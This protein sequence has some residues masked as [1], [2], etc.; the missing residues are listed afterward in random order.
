[1]AAVATS[2]RTFANSLSGRLL[3][4]TVVFV[5]LAEVPILATSIT[6][7]R[8]DYL[9]GRIAAAH[10]AYEEVEYLE[11]RR[12][13]LARRFPAGSRERG[14]VMDIPAVPE[15]RAEKL[16]ADIGVFDITLRRPEARQEILRSRY[17]PHDTV[18]RHHDLDGAS[19]MD[20][21]RDALALLLD[22]DDRLIRV[23]GRSPFPEHR[24]RIEITL[25]TA[26]MRDAMI[27]F[28]IRR[29]IGIAFVSAVT[30]ILLYL[31]AH[32]LLVRPIKRVSRYMEVYSRNPKDR[33][34]QI[35]PASGISEV[36]GMETS[37]Q[38]MQRH[39]TGAQNRLDR[40]ARLGRAIS[41]I[42]HDL[43]NRFTA[44]LLHADSM[45][46]E[47]DA[48]TVRRKAEATATPVRRAVPL[49]D[50]LTTYASSGVAAPSFEEF[51]LAPEIAKVAD[52]CRTLTEG[53]SAAI[54]WDVPANL[55][56][57]ADR[58]QIA[59]AIGNLVHN[60]LRAIA[61]TGK[62][63]TVRIRAA[64]AE[65]AWSIFVEDDGPG[66]PERMLRDLESVFDPLNEARDKSA[67]SGTG[68]SIV[69]DIM[70]AHGG[71][72]DLARSD[73]TGTV[74]VM[75]LPKQRPPGA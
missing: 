47:D 32:W 62:G 22:S 63:E 74:F 51:R 50:Q 5:T 42:A 31:A 8:Q 67:G 54:L 6:L 58:G 39:L 49:L 56:V 52:D 60:A 65:G 28:A 61:V 53:G 13:E 27:A 46:K 68:L 12:G 16:L 43:T 59:R 41:A 66:L 57:T 15:S 71:R 24:H 4:L 21:M 19:N 11:S 72:V 33:R 64:E 35:T 1:M 75:T 25:S 73:Q 23:I 2:R 7:F 9:L 37:L 40:Q 17:R 18:H 20:L 3:T 10:A 38:T 36:H 45:N 29:A 26:E 70:E 34:S 30:G 48:A 55:S 14:I 44:A 69:R